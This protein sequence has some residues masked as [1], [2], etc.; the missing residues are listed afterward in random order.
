M[1]R[2][3]LMGLVRAY[4]LLLSPWLGSACRFDP[5]CSVYSLQALEKHGAAAGSYLTVARLLR[6]HPWCAGGHDPVP[7]EA[8]RLFSRLIPPTSSKKTT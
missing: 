7:E 4:R 3:A 1:V 8:P 5:T 6:C 2:D